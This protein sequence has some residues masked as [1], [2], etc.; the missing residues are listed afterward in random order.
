MA[1]LTDGEVRE[2]LEAIKG[3]SDLQD[4]VIEDLL[5]EENIQGYINDVIQHGCVS[6]I[7]GSLCYYKDT[8]KFH[9]DY[10]EEIWDLLYTA[11]NDRGYKNIPEF[12][13]AL[14]GSDIG[15]MAELK[16][17]LCWFAYEET[18]NRINDRLERE[19]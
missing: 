12:I 2:K 18:I 6:G 8:T 14:H 4:R 5:E 13:A 15:S 11:T 19:V 9:D 3:E 7:C 10:E 1:K 17:L 16:N